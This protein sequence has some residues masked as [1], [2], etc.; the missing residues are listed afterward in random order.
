MKIEDLEAQLLK[1]DMGSRAR[2]AERL[3]VS[4]DEL[5]DVEI[6]QLWAAEALRRDIE[7]DKNPDLAVP[8][9]EVFSQAR[10]RLKK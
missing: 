9:D 7:M 2:L 3:L 6:E 10:S 5:S 1:L 8:A 4:L